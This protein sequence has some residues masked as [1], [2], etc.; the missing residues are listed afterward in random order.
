MS[1]KIAY[2]VIGVI[3]QIFSACS[4]TDDAPL[5]PQTH[6]ASDEL[7]RSTEDFFGDSIS[8]LY[9]NSYDEYEQAMS[10]IRSLDS[11]VEKSEWM[12]IT[13]PGFTSI[14]DI[15]EQAG[16]EAAVS[17]LETEVQFNS[18]MDKYA[19]LF[20]PLEEEDAGFYIPMKDTDLSYL[21]NLNCRIAIGDNVIDLKDIHDYSDLQECGRAFYEQ[22]G[23]MTLSSEESFYIKNP[24]MSSVGPEYDSGWQEYGKRKVKLKARRLLKEKVLSP[25][26]K[27]SESYFH[28][29][30][31]FRKKTFLGWSNYKCKSEI[32]GEVI[33]PGYGKLILD[34]NASGTSSHD[35][36][37]YYPIHIS[38]DDNF[39]YYRYLEAPCKATVKFNDISDPLNYSWVM[40]GIVFKTPLNGVLPE[41]VPYYQ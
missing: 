5:L 12:H 33:I 24:S 28:T 35:E 15:Y 25:L 8:I 4:N 41:V 36:E 17:D 31:C 20:F 13:Y 7:T 9:F 3:A 6:D 38:N 30:F 34:S 14:H 27:F 18:F 1:K 32:T 11:D 2:L 26:L 40:T 23:I 29:E 39:R 21:A 22:P 16:E 19:C 37:Y 10:H